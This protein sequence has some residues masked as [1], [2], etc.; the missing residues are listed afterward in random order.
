M[1]YRL[2]MR[3]ILFFADWDIRYLVDCLFYK[4]QGLKGRKWT[5]LLQIKNITIKILY[6]LTSNDFSPNTRT[7]IF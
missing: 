3:L 1:E 6:K 4:L 7:E 2:G 5:N